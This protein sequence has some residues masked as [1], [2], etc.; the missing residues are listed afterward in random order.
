MFCGRGI[1]RCRDFTPQQPSM[2]RQPP[3]GRCCERPKPGSAACPTWLCCSQRARPLCRVSGAA[4]GARRRLAGAQTAERIALAV[5]EANGCQYGLSLHTF[6]ARNGV[7]LDDAEI[8]ANRNGASNDPQ[9]AAAVCF[10]AKLVR[11]QGAVGD[12]DIGALKAAGYDDGLIIE[13]VLHAGLNT[14][15]GT[16]NKVCQPDIDFPPIQPRKA[17]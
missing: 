6:C 11:S 12:D 16:I 7:G 14:L 1:H 3:R 10:A 2:R 8:T 9:A 17:D 5:A 15:A 13:I 4:D